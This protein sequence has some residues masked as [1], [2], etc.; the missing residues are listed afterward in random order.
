MK[1]YRAIFAVIF[2]LSFVFLNASANAQ[3]ADVNGSYVGSV[4][5]TKKRAIVNV[6]NTRL[7]CTASKVPALVGYI[8]TQEGQNISVYNINY[9][10]IFAGKAT[11]TGFSAKTRGASLQISLGMNDI[12]KATLKS[13]LTLAKGVSCEF[14]YKGDLAFYPDFT[15]IPF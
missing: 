11:A 3:T 10:L 14:T 8:V 2:S 13:R 5:L 4:K 15:Y 1:V 9:E 6:R 7:K 12:A